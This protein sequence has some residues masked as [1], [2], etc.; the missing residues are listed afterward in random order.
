MKLILIL[1][2]LFCFENCIV[3]ALR[4]DIQNPI[5]VDHPD[6]V[7][8]IG[9]PTKFTCAYM[10]SRSDRV[11]AIRWYISYKNSN[12][13]FGNV[14]TYHA[15]TG[16]K[17]NSANG[18]S[19]FNVLT[20]T[21]TDKDL[22]IKFNDFK[23]SPI[24][25]K[26]E[27]ETH[28]AKVSREVDIPVVEGTLNEEDGNG[29]SHNG[30]SH[31]GGSHNGGSHNGGTHD[32][33]NDIHELMNLI[34]PRRHAHIGIPYDFH[35]GYLLMVAN[36]IDI[37]SENVVNSGSS[38]GSRRGSNQQQSMSVAHLYGKLPNAAIR[39]LQT[40]HRSRFTEIVD[41]KYK[42]EMNA[43]DVLNLLGKHNYRVIGFAT[44][45]DQKLVWTLEQRD[46]E[47]E[48]LNSGPSISQ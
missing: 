2:S 10:T 32:V 46:F 15:D 23:E 18:F 12:D 8:E 25:V 26:C 11:N 22:E 34:D 43:V 31:N 3:S 47:N 44:Q 30:G 7:I 21:A 20:H 38:Y 9:K 28:S 42:L 6:G 19:H 13:N 5:K 24:T 33:H 36:N 39:E 37:D 4:F 29:G 48:N 14:F 35:S 40:T 45:A 41:K 27:I 16:R 17:I 1:V